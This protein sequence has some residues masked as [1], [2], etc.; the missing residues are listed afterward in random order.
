MDGETMTP[1]DN[2]LVATSAL[3]SSLFK[4]IQADDID[5]Y[6]GLDAALK[7]G[8]IIKLETAISATG[9]F[10]TR[11]VLI[12]QEGKSMELAAL[13]FEERKGH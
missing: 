6:K 8:A 11:V 2:F 5:A 4:K 7:D 1:S 13:E 10:G 3:I 9:V 12:D